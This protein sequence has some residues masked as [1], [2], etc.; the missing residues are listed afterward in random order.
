MAS[1]S[2]Q[3]HLTT[4]PQLYSLDDQIRHK[5]DFMRQYMLLP[6]RPP[7]VVAAH[8]IGAYVAV[9]AVRELEQQQQKAEL[10]VGYNRPPPPILKVRGTIQQCLRLLSITSHSIHFI[11]ST[12]I[13]HRS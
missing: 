4:L 9:H 12:L 7:L 6:G 3:E 11:P 5:A 8:S 10:G 2:P 1:S 13:M